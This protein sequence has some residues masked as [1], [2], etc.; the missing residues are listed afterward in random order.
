M[1]C[2]A[3]PGGPSPNNFRNRRYSRPA[4]WI[5]TNIA[6]SAALS[7]QITTPVSAVST[8][9]NRS[10]LR[11]V[12]RDPFLALG[13]RLERPGRERVVLI[14]TATIGAAQSIPASLTHE[15]GAGVR[16]DFGAAGNTPVRWIRRIP[17][18]EHKRRHAG[19]R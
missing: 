7:A 1:Y 19:G 10:Q 2:Y 14:G 15:I 16:F 3:P 5:L 17:A 9:V 8:Y 4:Y 13:D 6:L 18:M 12:L 11:S